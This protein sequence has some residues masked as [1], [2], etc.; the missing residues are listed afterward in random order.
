MYASMH[1]NLCWIWW[2][3]R[4]NV[5]VQSIIFWTVSHT[6]RLG[7]LSWNTTVYCT[8]SYVVYLFNLDTRERFW[9][10]DILDFNPPEKYCAGLE[11]LEPVATLWQLFDDISPRRLRRSLGGVWNSSEQEMGRSRK[12]SIVKGVRVP[13]DAAL[14]R[15]WKGKKARGCLNISQHISWMSVTWWV[16][17]QWLSKNAPSK[18]GKQTTSWIWITERC[19]WK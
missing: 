5:Q 16:S 15:H 19:G 8:C 2:S 18:R 4:N 10:P 3:M 12:S 1:A 14:E 9:S 11:P 17:I 13:E 6:F 7:A